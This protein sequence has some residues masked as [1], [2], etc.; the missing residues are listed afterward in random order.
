MS[1]TAA[2]RPQHDA[3]RAAYHR[4][5]RAEEWVKGYVDKV[6]AWPGPAPARKAEGKRGA[7]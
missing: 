4:S 2:K 7:A 3:A 6:V 5:R 1:A